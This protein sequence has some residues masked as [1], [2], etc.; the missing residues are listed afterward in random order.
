MRFAILHISDLHRD[1]SNAVPNEW[2]LDSLHRDFDRFSEQQPKIMQPSLCIVSG[3]LVYG[4]K[5]AGDDAAAEM[6][7]QYLQAERLLVGLSDRFFRGNRER[8]IILPGNHDIS[9]YDVLRSAQKIDTPL[10]LERRAKLVSEL[11][12]PGSLLRWSWPE[13]SFYRIIDGEGYQQRFRYFATTYKNFYQGQRTYSLIPEQ[14]FGLHDFPD[15]EFCM[16]TLNSCYQNDQ[17]RQVAA[18][19]PGALTQ[20]CRF[21]RH[22]D[23]AGWLTAAAWHHNFM[24]GPT[25]NDYLD[26]EVLQLLIDA[27]VSLGFHGH[28]HLPDCIN[29]D[30]RIGK[31]PRKITVISASTLCAEPYHLQPGYPRSYNVVEIDTDAWIGRVHQRQMVNKLFDLPMWGPGHFIGT[32]ES[33]YDFELCKPILERPSNLDL[34]LALDKADRLIGARQWREAIDILEEIKG[35]PFARLLLSKA[36]EE[37]GEPRRTITNLWPPMTNVEAVMVGGAV[38]EIGTR[39]EAEAFVSIKLVQDSGDASVR[40]IVRRI[41]ERRL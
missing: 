41:Y 40:E 16:V 2:L 31:N 27:G 33:F 30:Y 10:E 9:F 24:G 32:N 39:E 36:L 18:F 20:A 6:D 5:L 38:L 19:H 15:L 21:L 23:R 26:A 22:N 12:A 29:E 37:L 35:N 17:F 34:Q 3:D 28:Q 7:R 8:I 1:T 25:R 11:F 14:Q 4:T 13:L